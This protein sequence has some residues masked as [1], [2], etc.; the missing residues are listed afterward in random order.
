MSMPQPQ[1]YS[2]PRHLRLCPR[3]DLPGTWETW[4]ASI[5][6]TVRVRH[7]ERGLLNL[8]LG[9]V[10]ATH[11]DEYTIAYLERT[12]RLGNWSRRLIE[13]ASRLARLSKAEALP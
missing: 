6:E 2:C 3:Y 11:R 5:R 12:L 4:Q 9:M 7:Q 13:Q 1:Y 10:E 8:W